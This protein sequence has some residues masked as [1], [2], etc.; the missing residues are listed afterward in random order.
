MCTKEPTN[1]FT[2]Q[3][4]KFAHGLCSGKYSKEKTEEEQVVKGNIEEEK[5]GEEKVQYYQDG[6]RPFMFKELVGKN[7]PEFKTD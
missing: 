7:H 6:I 3:M 1:C 4:A 2:C 5:E